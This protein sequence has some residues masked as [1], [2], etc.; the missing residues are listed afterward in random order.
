MKSLF[1]T[2]ARGSNRIG[3]LSDIVMVTV[4]AMRVVKRPSSGGSSSSSARSSS[5]GSSSAS[6]GSSSRSPIPPGEMLLAAGAAFRILR[7][8]RAVRRERKGAVDGATAA[9]ED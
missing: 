4:A 5:T 7:R 9:I 2:F 3:L 1:R 6:A 8:I